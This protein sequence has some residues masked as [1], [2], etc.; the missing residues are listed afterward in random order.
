MGRKPLKR[1]PNLKSSSCWISTTQRRR[2]IQRDR[3]KKLYPNLSP[4]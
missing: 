2:C 3:I 4:I 1:L